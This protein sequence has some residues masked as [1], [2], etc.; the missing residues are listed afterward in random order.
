[1]C[2][3]DMDGSSKTYFDE[4]GAGVVGQGVA[5]AGVLPTVAGDLE[6]AARTSRGE[7][8]GLG[9][10]QL[11][12]ATLAVVCQ[13]AGDAI[14]VFEQRRDRVFHVYF[15]ALVDL[16]MEDGCKPIWT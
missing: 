15:D 6:G 9:R 14:A 4:I 2:G 11:E 5:V 13:G 16:I 12:A 1:M 10:V 8:D 3:A 7:D